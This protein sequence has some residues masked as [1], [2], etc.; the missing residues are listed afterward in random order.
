MRGTAVLQ[1]MSLF[2]CHYTLSM[3]W[4]SKTGWERKECWAQIP[5]DSWVGVQTNLLPAVVQ[6]HNFGK[7]KKVKIFPLDPSLD[8]WV[9]RPLF[10]SKQDK[11]AKRE[12]IKDKNCCCSFSWLSL[13]VDF[14]L[15]S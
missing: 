8:I 13:H 14:Q 7:H 11:Q 4:Q 5:S 10:V 1:I 15:Y 6:L 12:E 9:F 2:R 3:W